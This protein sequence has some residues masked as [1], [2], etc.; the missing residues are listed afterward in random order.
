MADAVATTND[1]QVSRELARAKLETLKS[2][3]R[4]RAGQDYYGANESTIQQDLGG[5]TVE[6]ISARKN[7][8]ESVE[9]NTRLDQFR[10]NVSERARRFGQLRAQRAARRG[11]ISGEQTEARANAEASAFARQAYSR[12]WSL[13]EEGVE[14]FALSFLDF[15]LISGPTAVGIFIVR[16]IGGNLMGG[17]GTVSFRGVSVPRIPGYTTIP[18]G[19]YR[20]GKVLLIGLISGLIYFTI[21]FVV[22]LLTNPQLIVQQLLCSI[23]SGVLK[24]IGITVCTA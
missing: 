16:L 24:F 18:E 11:E 4:G 21:I 12:V 23:F 2:G 22:I 3:R 19:I 9:Q 5:D 14:D 13:I 15:M 17:A 1:L 20:F 8:P 7:V 6:N 10:E